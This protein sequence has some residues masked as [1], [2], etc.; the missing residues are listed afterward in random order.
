M[1]KIQERDRVRCASAFILTKGNRKT[2]SETLLEF[3]VASLEGNVNV[4]SLV[5]ILKIGKT[6]EAGTGVV[7]VRLMNTLVDS[8]NR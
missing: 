7:E 3:V 5:C 4:F 8:S 2:S 1:T 6:E